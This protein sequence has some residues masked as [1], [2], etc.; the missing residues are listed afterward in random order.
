VL[1]ALP[2]LA[3]LVVD[4]LHRRHAD[5]AARRRALGRVSLASAALCLVSAVLLAQHQG[6]SARGLAEVIVAAGGAH[7]PLVFVDTYRYDL[8]FYAGRR[9]APS[10]V[11]DWLGGDIDAHDNWLKE[12][13]DAARFEPAAAAAR[14]VDHAGLAALLCRSPRTWVVAPSDAAQR[15]AA[16]QGLAPVA[17]LSDDALWRVEFDAPQRRARCAPQGD[18]SGVSGAA[19]DGANAQ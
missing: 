15:L 1:P 5:A 19:A 12:V 10:V 4:A 18:A 9:Q 2:P 8:G 13:H 6:R 3:L 16:L 7:D 17:R 14:L 11:A